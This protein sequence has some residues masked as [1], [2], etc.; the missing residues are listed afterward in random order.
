MLR[1]AEESD[2]HEDV[3]Y[4]AESLFTSI[5]VKEMFDYI[6]QKIYVKKE[7]KPFCKKPVKFFKKLL[8]KFPQECVFSINNRLIKKVDGCPMCEL[9][10]VVFQIFM[11]AKWRKI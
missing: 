8:R 4:D 2:K 9:I 3:S 11:Y 7:I 5:P 6:I 1:N 10:S